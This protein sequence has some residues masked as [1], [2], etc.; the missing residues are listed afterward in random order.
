MSTL[1][2]PTAARCLASLLPL[3][4]CP[5]TILGELAGA[6][7]S[8]GPQPDASMTWAHVQR[9]ER[10]PG[11]EQQLPCPPRGGS[12][13]SS[14]RCFAHPPGSMPVCTPSGRGSE[15]QGPGPH[16]IPP[17]F[18]AWLGR[19][20]AGCTSDSTCPGFSINNMDIARGTP[21]D[22]V[23]SRGR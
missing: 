11:R 8:R 5:E 3:D 21:R 12:C 23:T 18:P 13:T 15:T 14:H 17:G 19:L 7:E 9:S 1:S 16:E 20:P 22:L 6:G 10:G 4:S 2:S